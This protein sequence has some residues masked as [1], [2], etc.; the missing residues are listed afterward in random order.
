MKSYS[1]KNIN[2]S[3]SK[4]E[5]RKDDI[6]LKDGRSVAQTYFPGRPCRVIPD[7]NKDVGGDALL[8]RVATADGRKND[9]EAVMI[10]KVTEDV[11]AD[12][13]VSTV[14]WCGG[15]LKDFLEMDFYTRFDKYGSAIVNSKTGK[16]VTDIKGSNSTLFGN[17]IYSLSDDVLT[18]WDYCNGQLKEIFKGKTGRAPDEW[19]I[20]DYNALDVVVISTEWGEFQLYCADKHKFI[21]SGWCTGY[22]EQSCSTR[23]DFANKDCDETDI[24][25]LSIQ[26]D[27]YNQNKRIVI[28]DVDTLEPVDIEPVS[29][30]FDLPNCYIPVLKS[31]S[32]PYKYNILGSDNKLVLDEWATEIKELKEKYCEL[33]YII[34]C[35]YDDGTFDIVGGESACILEN[36][37]FDKMEYIEENNTHG[38]LVC[39]RRK[40]DGKSNIVDAETLEDKKYY[41]DFQWSLP[42]WAD[43]ILLLKTKKTSQIIIEYGNEHKTYYFR[44]LIDG[45]TKLYSN[46]ELNVCIVLN[47]DGVSIIEKLDEEESGEYIYSFEPEPNYYVKDAED[48]SIFF[49]GEIILVTYKDKC[50]FIDSY[51]SDIHFYHVDGIENNTYFEDADDCKKNKDDDYIYHVKANGRWMWIDDYSDEYDENGEPI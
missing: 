45:I 31:L 14:W 4:F 16:L 17:I 3:E 7:V 51:G 26:Y 19:Q 49:K 1:F 38:D 2:E 29:E 5:I 22:K 21:T 35:E 20:G 9:M 41:D 42:E 47:D 23:R 46:D 39:F 10:S 37:P 34:K 6:I 40:S 36:G 13:C 24:Q 15:D 50:K 27:G 30:V 33:G 48:I 8:Y 12:V 28:Y 44:K 11:V 25:Y 43:D 18:V 32:K